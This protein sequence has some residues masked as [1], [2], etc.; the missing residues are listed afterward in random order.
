AQMVEANLRRADLTGANLSNANLQGANLTRTNLSGT[1]LSSADL[2]GADLRGSNLAAAHLEG[3]NLDGATIDTVQARQLQKLGVD[4]SGATVT[5]RTGPDGQPAEWDQD[6]SINAALMSNRVGFPT[7]SQLDPAGASPNYDG[8]ANCAPASMAMMIRAA[9]PDTAIAVGDMVMRS[10]DL[11]DAQLISVLGEIGGTTKQNL[12]AGDPG[13]TSLNGVAEMAW[14]MGQPVSVTEVR[15]GELRPKDPALDKEW[16]DRQLAAGKSVIANGRLE[17]GTQSF[18]HYMAVVGRTK[19]GNY[20]VNDPWTNRQLQYTPD[21]LRSYLE[22][23]SQ[24][25]GAMMAIGGD[26]GYKLS[27]AAAPTPRADPSAPATPGST[28]QGDPSAPA[29]PTPGTPQAAPTAPA[30]PRSAP[31]PAAPTAPAAPVV[32]T[33]TAAPSAPSGPIATPQ[34]KPLTASPRGVIQPRPVMV[35]PKPETAPYR[36]LA[37]PALKAS[38]YAIQARQP[39]AV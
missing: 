36:P 5:S 37:A 4:I 3:A 34:A 19:G 24:Y 31:P 25:G 10:G 1:D 8:Q 6:Q 17:D 11:S 26:Q 38:Q 2:S 29:G 30:T 12:R 33:P 27:P 39:I 28:P 22:N 14:S 35:A 9:G 7:M 20:V 23:N 32:R 13:G 21:Q 15:G 18:D 16:L